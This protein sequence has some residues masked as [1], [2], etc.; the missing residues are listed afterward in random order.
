LRFGAKAS[1]TP[2]RELNK[3]KNPRETR[4]SDVKAAQAH[5]IDLDLQT[6]IDHWSALPDAL[7]AGIVA[8]VRASSGE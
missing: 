6:I 2:L 4:I 3:V 1:S 5:L 8:M 7:K